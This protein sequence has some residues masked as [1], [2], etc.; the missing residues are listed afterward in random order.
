MKYAGGLLL[1]NVLLVAAYF[2][3]ATAVDNKRILAF[4]SVGVCIGVA[5][6]LC[7]RLTRFKIPGL[8]DMS[9]TVEQVKDDANEVSAIKNRVEAQSATVDLIAK[10][11]LCQCQSNTY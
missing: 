6:M 11:R 9:S 2:L 3:F 8:A 1:V 5:I 4:T 10:H 7:D